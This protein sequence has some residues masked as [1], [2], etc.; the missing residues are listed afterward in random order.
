MLLAVAPALVATLVF[1]ASAFVGIRASLK[2]YSPT[3]VAL[4][5]Y[6]VASAVLAVYALRRRVPIPAL[7][8]WPRV[9]LAGAAGFTVYNLA[10]NAGET[11]VTAGAASFVGNTV[12]VFTALLASR[13]LGERLGVRQLAGLAI[14]L[15]GAGLIAAGEGGGVRLEP[16]VGLVVV[17]ALA[18][19]VYF[20]LQRPLLTHQAPLGVTALALWFGTLLLLPFLPS[21]LH[22]IPRAPLGA[23]ITVAYLGVCPGAIGYVA[24]SHVLARMPAARASSFLYVVP[25]LTILIGWLWLREAPSLLSLAGGGVALAGVVVVNAQRRR[26]ETKDLTDCSTEMRPGSRLA[27]T[28]SDSGG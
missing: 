20:C 19:S 8:D 12:P 15:A 17:A 2:D 14:S 7:R 23:T 25:V 16:A 4:L 13:F 6:L 9:L 24:W 18:Q 3:Q 21:L 28:C 11:R 1:W 5:R 10:L 27:R 22:Q 26:T